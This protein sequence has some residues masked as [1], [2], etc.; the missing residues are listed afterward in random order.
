MRWDA[1]VIGTGFGGA[2]SALRL[3]ESGRRVLVLEQGRRFTP[4]DLERSGRR[5]RDLLWAPAARLTGPLR[6]T[7]LRHL[8]VVSGVGVGGGS[9]V[10][11]A[12]HLRAPDA[13]FDEWPRV[14][15][16]WADD[17]R[18]Y[19][20]IAAQSLGSQVNPGYGVQDAWLSQ[21]AATMGVSGTYGPTPQGIDFDTCVS[22][23]Q[24][25][26]GCPH[27]AKT[28]TTDTYLQRAETAGAVVRPLST[29]RRIDPVA[30]GSYRVTMVP[31]LG[32]GRAMTADASMVVLSAGVL[33]TTELLLA[34]RDR[35][36]SLP[37]LSPMLGRRVR[38]NSESFVAI[39]QPRGG[40]DLLDGTTISSDFWPDEVTHVTNN[41]FPDSY[42][43]M[44]A[45]LSPLIEADTPTERRRLLL[46]AYVREGLPLMRAMTARDWN[47]RTTV[48]TVMQNV[49]SELELRYRRTRTGWRLG[50][51]LG[52][53]V[54]RTPTYI[55]QAAAAGRAVA[56][57]SG[58]HAYGTVLESVL[59]ISTTAHVLGGAAIG[60]DA[61][62]GVIDDRHEAFG[63]P[64]LYVV[65]GSAVPANIGV[66][67]SLTITALAERAMALVAK[68]NQGAGSSHV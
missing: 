66:N 18:P 15:A 54:T 3:A 36:G 14:G 1:I 61:A 43:F 8:F 64:G 53:G 48:L 4:A 28:T 33:G 56:N 30:D 5:T 23:A 20:E 51:G 6:Q 7:A 9:L 58:G 52:E 65:D 42:S 62:E 37:S 44:R 39:T 67:P 11:A 40:P 22:C 26:S 29:V 41:R 60:R 49:E 31:T 34:C 13:A 19:Y 55:P 12:V 24:C 50:S 32:R 35:F 2:V 45:F 63:Y 68:E 21:A 38:T 47:R 59:G 17:L 25:I 57:A 16:P 27:G 46:R 10:Y